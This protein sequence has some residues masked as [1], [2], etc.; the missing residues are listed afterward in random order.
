[1]FAE[2]DC[3]MLKKELPGVP[4]KV[5]DVGV[6]LI[7]HTVPSVAYEV[8]FVN[9]DATAKAILTLTEDYME[10]MPAPGPDPSP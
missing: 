4:V 5:G 2:Y 9:P 6:V 1:M 10:E 3:F 7:V 8:E